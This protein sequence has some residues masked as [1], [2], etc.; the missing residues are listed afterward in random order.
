MTY[1]KGDSAPRRGHARMKQLA[2]EMRGEIATIAAAMIAGL[3]RPATELETLQAEAIAALHL[4]ARRQRD[5]GRDDIEH[6]REA[7][8]M[9]SNSVF[10]H[11]LDSS[12][13]AE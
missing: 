9:T 6:L 12:P 1:T 10:R 3:N 4:R 13:R 8:I 7:A 5:A 2:D 11:P